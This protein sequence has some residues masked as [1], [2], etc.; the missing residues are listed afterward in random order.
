MNAPTSPPPLKPGAKSSELFVSL[1][2]A[3]AAAVYGFLGDLSET[4]K[5]IALA[6]VA[7][8]A[9][10]YTLSRGKAKSGASS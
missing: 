8:V 1:F 9:I 2:A 4:G 6:I 7:A 10:G 5:L 3:L